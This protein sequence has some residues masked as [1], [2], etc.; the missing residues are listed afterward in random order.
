MMFRIS[1]GYPM[2]PFVVRIRPHVRP[3]S[4]FVPPPAVAFLDPFILVDLLR[5]HCCLWRRR[6]GREAVDSLLPFPLLFFRVG[7]LGE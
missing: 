5:V 2:A 7:C 6:P 4:P 1:I 3:A